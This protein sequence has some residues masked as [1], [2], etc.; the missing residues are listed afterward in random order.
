MDCRDDRCYCA[1][2]IHISHKYIGNNDNGEF[3]IYVIN[4][5]RFTNKLDAIDYM[6]HIY[7]LGIINNRAYAI[8]IKKN[9]IGYNFHYSG[10]TSFNKDECIN[11]INNDIPNEIVCYTYELQRDGDILPEEKNYTILHYACEDPDVKIETI[12]FL[13]NSGWTNNIKNIN[14][15]SPLELLSMEK[16]QELYEHIINKL[17]NTLQ[18]ANKRF[19]V[20]EFI[21]RKLI[22]N[23]KSCYIKNM[24]NNFK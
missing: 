19:I 1:R 4:E 14:N 23:P 9:Y 12:L 6:N 15:K 18:S 24:I 3:G 7:D 5:K 2:C 16:S 22:Y 10:L 8:T 20:Y 21:K 17:K 11:Y 13:I